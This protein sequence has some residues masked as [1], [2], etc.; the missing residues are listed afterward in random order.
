MAENTKKKKR[1]TQEGKEF[2][3]FVGLTAAGIGGVVVLYG[4]YLRYL[5][6]KFNVEVEKIYDKERSDRERRDYDA[7]LNY[8][9]QYIC[10]KS[11]KVKDVLLEE[12]IITGDGWGLPLKQE[13]LI[14][15]E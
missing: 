10:G 5:K 3:T 12:G 1:L 7:Y 15:K 9:I 2:L 11:D 13:D 6:S 8:F 4:S 14:T